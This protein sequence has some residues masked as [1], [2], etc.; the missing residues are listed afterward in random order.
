MPITVKITCQK[1]A[2]NRF[3]VER[4]KYSQLSCVHSQ[5]HPLCRVSIKCTQSAMNRDLG[6]VINHSGVLREEK[7]SGVSSQVIRGNA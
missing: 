3:K 7:R 5:C 2:F 4:A 1:F 6:H